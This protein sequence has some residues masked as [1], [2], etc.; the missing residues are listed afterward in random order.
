MKSL[1][2]LTA[3]MLMLLSCGAIAQKASFKFGK[4][5]PDE[6]VMTECSFSKDA[7]A[8]VI[9]DV[10]VIRFRYN[11]DKGFQ[12]AFD[13]TVRIKI[14]SQD[15]SDLGNVVVRV[16]KG[17]SGKEEVSGIKGVTY[18]LEDGQVLESKLKNSDV[19]TEQINE[20]WE[21]VKFAL[22]SVK[23]GSV[24]EYT[25][26]ITSD[27][28]SNL[29]TWEFQDKI[30]VQWSEIDIIIP[31]FFNYQNIFRGF[32]PLAVDENNSVTERFNYSYQKDLNANM[33]GGS[34]TERGTFSSLSK[35]LRWAASKVE[36]LKQ[37]PFMTSIMDYAFQVE[38]Q[39]ESIKYPNSPLK[40]VAGSY[41]KI[42]K[43][44]LEH[45]NFG[46]A[47]DKKLDL[48]EL[49][50]GTPLPESMAERASFIY[51]L[52]KAKME[53]NEFNAVFASQS[54]N[55]ILKGG[56]GSVADI[57]L[58][59]VSAFRAAGLESN[60]VVISTR[61]NGKMHPVYP[62]YDRMNYV[63]AAVMIDGKPYFADASRKSLSFNLLPEFCMNGEAWMVTPAGGQWV[64]VHGNSFSES[65]FF[66]MEIADNRIFGV[67]EQKKD[68][69]S[70]FE[71]RTSIREQGVEK[72]A[73]SL[74]DKNVDW[75]IAATKVDWENPYQPLT[76][77]AN[78]SA[79]FDGERLYVNPIFSGI[80]ENPFKEEE[81]KM[82]IDIPYG[83]QVKSF[84]SLN[85]PEGYTIAEIP[86]NMVMALP[87]KA[88][89]FRY[90]ASQQGNT[91]S[92]TSQF[93][94]SRLI[95]TTEEYAMLKEFYEKMVAKNNEVLVLTKMTK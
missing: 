62:S 54:V 56:K 28:I 55:Q 14:F 45:T 59:L 95:Y 88:G 49:T 69:Y 26:T 83:Y 77:S 75:E 82:H 78:I 84:F 58:S 43:E 1:K 64:N 36:P 85:L 19:F 30:P 57:N 40:V 67:L 72:Y 27:F 53:W 34:S 63:V 13:R 7:K 10:G 46:K 47:L 42:N 11:S 60:P 94:L 32:A 3:F 81:R 87:D 90:L 25:Y 71:A 48:A 61:N 92:I 86:E 79:D 89:M 51:E 80:K 74:N 23:E 65:A 16:Y 50:S 24:F 12:F 70:G 35:H 22:P 17:N 31:E 29:R 39:L 6:L 41:D 8:M 21:A 52:I 5:N 44:L 20:R 37:E 76:V 91:I 2:A 93:T 66:K 18:N 4:P 9:G 38:F 73:Q 68:G 15:A 33:S